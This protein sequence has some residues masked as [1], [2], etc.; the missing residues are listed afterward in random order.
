MDGRR[1]TRR[2]LLL[3]AAALPALTALTA[4][5]ALAA[6]SSPTRTAPEELV[7]TTGPEGAVFREI[8]AALAAALAD[9]LPGT[10]VLARP[11]SASVENLARLAGGEAQLGLASLDA[12]MTEPGRC[13]PGLGA[14]ARLYDSFLHLVVPAGSPVRAW[15][16]LA[17]R[18]VAMGLDRSG[19]AFTVRRLLPLTGVRFEELLLSQ[20]DAAGAL[21]EGTIDAFLTLT[22]IPTPAI[23]RLA[24]RAPIRLVPLAGEAVALANAHPGPYVPA[25]IPAT[26]YPDVPPCP[27]VAVPNLL[28]A[29]DDLPA[30]VV[31]V[32]TATVFTDAARIAGGHPEAR[33]INVRTGIA[34]GPVPLHAGAAAWFRSAKR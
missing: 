29:R 22:G 6:C 27:T 20:A 2:S 1:V 18:R 13:P 12:V 5:S 32:V 28:L 3:G 10:R 8:G 21:A 4:L 33:R 26:T 16:D 11:S 30:P 9:H 25:T 34:T 14:V 7:L 19:T 24:E 17:G 15:G 31:E 23:S